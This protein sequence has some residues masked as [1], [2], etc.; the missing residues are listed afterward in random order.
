MVP[1]EPTPFSREHF[2]MSV[3]PNNEAMD[4]LIADVDGLHS[5]PSVAQRILL[6]T[7]N[8][9]FRMKDVVACLE[10]DPGLAARILRV[11]NSSRYGLGRQISS[12]RHAATYLGQRSLRLFA[13]TFSLVDT[14]A[15]GVHKGISADYWSRALT[16]AAIAGR[17]AK[18][19]SDV[20]EN[21]GYTTGLL[22]DVGVLVFAQTEATLYGPVYNSYE[23]GQPLVDSEEKLF[24]F[25][26][27]ALGAR[28]LEKW[29]LPAHI[30]LAV[31]DHHAGGDE[32]FPLSRCVRAGNLAADALLQ[33]TSERVERLADE[34]AA[35]FS[36]ST[37]ELVELAEACHVDMRDNAAIF[38]ESPLSAEALKEFVEMVRLAASGSQGPSEVATSV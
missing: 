28:L 32:S 4:R 21:D 26:H 36:M 17:L 2:I 23:H 10:H 5:S 30:V 19:Q 12:I 16:M 35:H 9:D 8:P 1:P 37:G 3:S 22:A 34:M 7:R 25:S 14:L 27:A 24:G 38:G 31:A 6:L 20:E 33:P 15:K 18:E 11:V 29:D 13:V